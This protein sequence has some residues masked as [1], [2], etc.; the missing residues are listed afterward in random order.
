MSIQQ[1]PRTKYIHEF[2]DG[3][4]I[5]A[6]KF[7]SPQTGE[8]EY[9]QALI[10]IH[11]GPLAGSERMRIKI[12]SKPDYSASSLL[13]TS[14]WANFDDIPFKDKIRIQQGDGFY[15]YFKVD[16]NQ[17]NIKA[18]RAYWMS[19]EIDGYTRDGSNYFISYVIDCISP[20][21]HDNSGTINNMPAAFLLYLNEA[22]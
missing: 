4:E 9:I 19:Y 6:A 3:E 10:Y 1:I 2:D 22:R 14:E 18:S 16:F 11:G 5:A 17:E 15:G 7:T 20:Y 21:Y 13:Y 12:F 8:L